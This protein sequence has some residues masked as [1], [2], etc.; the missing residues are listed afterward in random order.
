M[1]P[2]YWADSAAR[3]SRVGF[4]G[5]CGG[6]I[7]RHSHAPALPLGLFCDVAARHRTMDSKE[8]PSRGRLSRAAQPRRLQRPCGGFHQRSLY[9]PAMLRSIFAACA[10]VVL[11]LVFGVPAVLLSL[12]NPRGD[13]V[14]RFG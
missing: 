13:W 11:T 14:L 3:R 8:T 9:T 7:T 5:P 6:V 4:N 12:V 1:R 2:F 10:T